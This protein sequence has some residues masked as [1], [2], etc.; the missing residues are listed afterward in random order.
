[1]TSYQDLLARV[2]G[3][4]IEAAR[5]DYRP[6]PELDGSVAGFEAC[7]GRTPEQLAALLQEARL[8]ARRGQAGDYWFWR[9]RELEVEWVCNVVS[10]A[11]LNQGLP[12]IVTPTARGVFKAAEILGV[13]GS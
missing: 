7:R 3:D 4:G 13:A 6:G 9:C 10:A 2:I 1:M 8:E 12:V 5:V 11:L